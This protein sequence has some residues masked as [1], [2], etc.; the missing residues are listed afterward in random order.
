[1]SRVTASAVSMKQVAH[2]DQ[3][4]TTETENGSQV[5][6]RQN[7]PMLDQSQEM[8]PLATKIECPEI[9]NTDITY[10]GIYIPSETQLI[11]DS[12]HV[13]VTVDKIEALKI[14]KRYK[15]ARFKA[16]KTRDDAV[17]FAVNGSEILNNISSTHA[18][19]P[20]AASPLVFEK[21]SL[22]K[23]PKAQDLVQL[24]KQIE[25]GDLKSVSSTVWSNPRYLVSSGDTPAILQEGSRYNALHVAAKARNTAMCE[26]IIQTVSDPAF[27]GLL[28]GDDDP[29]SCQERAAILLDL[30]LN[31]PDKGLNET[32]LHF[33]VKFGAV[34]VVEALVS[35]P[36]CD[37]NP[38]NKFGQSPKDIVCSRIS[39]SD[40]SHNSHNLKKEIM[41][42]LDERFYVPVLRSEDNSVQP[43]V[44]SPFSPSCPLALNTDPINPRME[45]H[46]YAG[47]MSHD[48]AVVFRKK[49]KTPP[50]IQ[51]IPFKNGPSS[52]VA[53]ILR[54]QDTE[55]GLER[56]GRELAQEFRVSWK[57]FWPFLG[58]FTDL[59]TPE[60]LQ[61]LEVYLK[62]RFM[63]VFMKSPP[64]ENF[65]S[66]GVSKEQSVPVTTTSKTDGADG[67]ISPMSDLCLAFKACSL[68]D[69][70]S[71]QTTE[72]KPVMKMINMPGGDVCANAENESLLN[73]LSNPGLSPFLYVEK[74]CQVFAKRIGD[75]LVHLVVMEEVMRDSQPCSESVF[76]FLL[77]EVKHLQV[78]VNSYMD[79]PRFVTVDFHLIHSRI[80]TLVA[81]KIIQLSS[82]DVELIISC[83]KLA[84]L[85]HKGIEPPS[86]DEED[87]TNSNSLYR[88]RKC[89]ERRK[90]SDISS[91]NHVKCLSQ[92]IVDAL[93]RLEENE[94][95]AA[96]TRV[97][98]EDECMKVWSD[99]IACTCS[100]HMQSLSRN[101][102]KGAS[103]KRSHS[104]KPVVITDIAVCH[105]N[106]ISSLNCIS[107]RL[108]YS[109][110][111]NDLNVSNSCK[112]PNLNTQTGRNDTKGFKYQADAS[113]TD[114]GSES[115]VD[116]AFYTPPTSP[117][118][119]SSEEEMATADEGIGVYIEG[120]NPSKMDLAV[121]QAIQ[122]CK[123]TA[124]EYPNVY[125]WKHLVLLHSEKERNSWA[126]PATLRRLQ[127]SRIQCT[128]S[129]MSSSTRVLRSPHDRTSPQAWH[130]VAGRYTPTRPNCHAD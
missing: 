64:K 16:F 101:S 11:E 113:D 41:S 56:V 119:A 44:G 30:Y 122:D 45:I 110:C 81:T 23:G 15:K 39:G 66:T 46:A 65:K 84:L 68:T 80:A 43:V 36:Q 2:S 48:E 7:T 21:P 54:L 112:S 77:V 50:R 35:C 5:H 26:F 62:N 104:M 96:D 97:D 17:E 115:D 12:E 95:I 47:P 51:R 49:W 89:V 83:L 37:K 72:R 117:E 29:E 32:P 18:D 34:G 76:D 108:S 10:Y 114:D 40:A 92:S 127:K 102:R 73:V 67:A 79:D 121:L 25:C 82:W 75:G 118:E 109:G 74:S 8:G 98:T 9:V 19:V 123:I 3:Q 53:T 6:S 78:L 70:P 88:T 20:E 103:L 90:K 63:Q 86:S 61:K 31:T 100:W 27:V 52:T 94:N 107:R 120:E 99:A 93:T 111:D 128:A 91:K 28:Y 24:R 42:L 13:H 57:E 124:A 87:I 106:K 22:F 59:C 55:K 4:S 69:N 60:G 85:A 105:D 71:I 126:S 58:I 130:R 125:R 38:K 1:M 33:A 14:V 116:E 129:P